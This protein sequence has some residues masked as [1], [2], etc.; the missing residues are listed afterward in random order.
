MFLSTV[1]GSRACYRN[2]RNIGSLF[3]CIKRGGDINLKD[4][5]NGYTYVQMRSELLQ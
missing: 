2:L 5:H 1:T 3:K 4:F